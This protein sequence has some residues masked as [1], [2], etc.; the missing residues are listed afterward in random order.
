MIKD[1]PY[2]YKLSNSLV[3]T[4]GTKPFDLFQAIK[5]LCQ[6]KL[7]TYEKRN[8]WIINDYKKIDSILKNDITLFS[9]IIASRFKILKQNEKLYY[10]SIKLFKYMNIFNHNLPKD[11][12]LDNCKEELG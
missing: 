8:S 1:F 4:I 11:Y 5:L 12:I 7:V 6:M 3:D 2:R 10:F 9:N